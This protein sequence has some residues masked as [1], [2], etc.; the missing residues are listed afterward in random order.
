MTNVILEDTTLLMQMVSPLHTR[1]NSEPT[2]YGEES[3]AARKSIVRC[4]EQ[5]GQLSVH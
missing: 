5:E 1:T 2:G 4:M 3:K